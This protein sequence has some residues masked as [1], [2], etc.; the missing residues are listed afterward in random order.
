MSDLAIQAQSMN[1][2]MN[3]MRERDRENAYLLRAEIRRVHA[4]LIQQAEIVKDLQRVVDA[5]YAS[6]SS[7]SSSSASSPLR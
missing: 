3:L 7:R 5:R 1:V 2:N 4:A 6:S